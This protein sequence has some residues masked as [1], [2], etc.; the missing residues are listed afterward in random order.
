MNPPAPHAERIAA[1]RRAQIDAAH[2]L[3]LIKIV[4]RKG[5]VAM[6]AAVET[7]TKAVKRRDA[8]AKQLIAWGVALEDEARLTSDG[9]G[10]S[11]PP[12]Q[13]S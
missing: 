5:P 12:V 13:S 1:F 7:A 2:K 11:L 9:Q 3:G 6:R 8:L 4:Q 10:G